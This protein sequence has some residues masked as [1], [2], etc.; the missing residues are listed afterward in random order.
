[1]ALCSRPNIYT[2]RL[3]LH[4]ETGD[5][6][7]PHLHHLRRQGLTQTFTYWHYQVV[8]ILQISPIILRSPSSKGTLKKAKRAA[9][10]VNFICKFILISLLR[11]LSYLC[12]LLMLLPFLSIYC[13]L[14]SR[15]RIWLCHLRTARSAA[16]CKLTSL[17]KR[18]RVHLGT[19]CLHHLPS[20]NMILQ[21][22]VPT[23]VL[24][25]A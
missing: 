14:A 20:A 24:R 13:I 6:H 15:L 18:L 17:A 19:I 23:R 11:C 8:S 21:L 12:E 4:H 2:H 25:G 9:Y 22:L 7:Y 16:F 10:V 3:G 5:R 1:L